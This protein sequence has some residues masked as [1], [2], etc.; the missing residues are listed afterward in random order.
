MWFPFSPLTHTLSH[1]DLGFCAGPDPG[2]ATVWFYHM[3]KHTDV[4]GTD[5]CT[6][7]NLK[8]RA[9]NWHQS[10]YMY[11]LADMTLKWSVIYSTSMTLAY[12]ADVMHVKSTCPSSKQH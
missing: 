1:P 6:V 2:Q 8:H 4:C 12:F 5:Y 9:T 10:I 3:S 7:I 11:T